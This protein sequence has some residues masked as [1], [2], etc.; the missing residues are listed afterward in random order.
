MF[1][2]LCP[3]ALC[4]EGN[5]GVSV[6]GQIHEI[7][8]AVYSI[9]IDR[10]R[11]TR[12]V[13]GERQPAFPCKRVDEAGFADVAST[14]EGY[15]GQPVDG[16]LLGTTGT[17]NE[18]CYQFYYTGRAGGCKRFVTTIVPRFGWLRLQAGAGWFW[19]PGERPGI[20]LRVPVKS[21]G[22]LLPNEARSGLCGS[23]C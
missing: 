11:A 6:A 17:V 13:T 1:N 19:P 14:Q 23:F 8:T 7:E 20:G 16:E 21:C 5:L 3:L 4:C 9:E 22:P 18:F 10:L 15:L 2:E 12:R